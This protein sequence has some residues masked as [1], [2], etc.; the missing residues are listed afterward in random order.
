MDY[1]RASYVGM[2]MSI[3]EHRRWKME[4]GAS[5]PEVVYMRIPA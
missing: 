1:V 5:S 2:E 4:D 3:A